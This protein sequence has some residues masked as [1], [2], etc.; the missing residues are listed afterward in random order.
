MVAA[1]YTAGDFEQ[2]VANL[3]YLPRAPVFVPNPTNSSLP[4]DF[5]FYLDLNR[6]GL[7]ETNG[8]VSE[9]DNLGNLT[10]A[11][12]SEVGDP[13]WVGVLERPDVPHG[14]NNKFISRYAFVAVPADGSLD[15]NAIHNQTFSTAVP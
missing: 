12:I 7:F 5:R 1:L 3:L 14:P 15:L 8:L 9:I 6:N 2:N 13:E 10:G 11:T 4:A